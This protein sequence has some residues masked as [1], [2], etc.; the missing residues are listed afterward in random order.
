MNLRPFL[1]ALVCLV[2]SVPAIAGEYQ[3]VEVES[4]RVTLDTMW[5]NQTA[6][7]YWPVRLDITNLG[8][9][10][11]IEIYG[12]GDRWWRSG[13]SGNSEIR[14]T[15]HLK[16]GDRQRFT[17]PVPTFG[18]NDSVLFQIREHG[19]TIQSFTYAGFQSN[20]TLDE[21]SALVVIDPASPLG[22]AAIG[23]LRSVPVAPAYRMPAAASSKLDFILDPSRLP[24]D[25]L[26]YTS[27]RAVFIGAK[28]WSQ[29]SSVQKEALLTWTACGGDFVVV[30]GDLDSLLPD[31]QS[32]P[33]GMATGGDDPI[34][35][36]FGHIRLVKSAD[37]S[38]KGLAE[39]LSSS[40]NVDESIRTLPANRAPDWLYGT[41]R[42]F[43]LPIPGVAGVPVR[44]YMTILL[45]FSILIGPVNYILL[46]RKRRQVL[47]VLTAPLISMV[48][49][50]VLAGYAVFG[51][52]I[53]IKGRAQSFTVLD[54][55][56][57]R[58]VTRASI[59]LYAAGMTPW[60]GLRFPKS[61]AVFPTGADG[62]GSRDPEIIDL[63]ESQQFS[64]GIARA[65]APSNF[66]EISFRLARE[67]LNFSR[68]GENITVVNALG[69]NVNQL[70]YRSGGVLYTLAGPLRD[71]AQATMNASGKV[72]LIALPA[73]FRSIANH[74]QDGT[75]LAYLERSPFLET[76]APNVEERGSFHLVLGYAGDGNE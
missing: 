52:G 54:Q 37:I 2:F 21:T 3:T 18:D 70:S 13:E 50:A 58:A 11:V 55:T 28:E 7:G 22:P 57:K 51:E 20:K 8:D 24:T 56:T 47:L 32:R 64:S 14:Q 42:G 49:L 9:D 10:R 5:S 75:Y 25:W 72:D 27:L 15:L 41:D 6:P 67:R 16:R 23:W 33:A 12:H 40:R 73:K 65:R 31:K 4:L 44:S 63:T 26:G 1:C 19:R 35:Y 30:D 61:T 38:A 34:H 59:S 71:G 36:Y 39:I 48:F 53:G 69:S 62:R 45:A 17:I 66:E 29:L 60:N 43:R 46:W 74:Q 76:G 68:S